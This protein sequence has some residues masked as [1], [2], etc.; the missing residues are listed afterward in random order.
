MADSETNNED[1]GNACFGG[2]HRPYSASISDSPSHLLPWWAWYRVRFRPR[3][4]GVTS[5][6]RQNAG[7]RVT[8]AQ[9]AR[10][11]SR[12]L[13]FDT[14]IMHIEM[15]L[16]Q[17]PVPQLLSLHQLPSVSDGRRGDEEIGRGLVEPSCQKCIPFRRCI[18]FT[19]SARKIE[20]GLL[21]SGQDVRRQ[22]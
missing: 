6:A 18:D 1:N 22:C 9:S 13:A 4:W 8:E 7:C 10:I 16:F 19:S 20:H 5:H 3:S 11:E 17:N 2:G 21:L 14:D 12:L 15:T